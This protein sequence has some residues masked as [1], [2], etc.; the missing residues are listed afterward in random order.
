MSDISTEFC[1]AF[2]DSK[3]DERLNVIMGWFGFR[4][5][6]S[7]DDLHGD[8]LY[9]IQASD[10]SFLVCTPAQADMG[11]T[12]ALSS[13]VD[14]RPIKPFTRKEFL[15]LGK[16]RKIVLLTKKQD[17]SGE[18]ESVDAEQTSAAGGEQDSAE[19]SEA[20]SSDSSEPSVLDMGAFG[21]LLTAA[22]RS[23]LVAGADQ[24]AYV[25][26]REFR[27]GKYD[28]AF[29]AIDAM[30]SRF[31]TSSSQRAQQLV[32]EDADIAAGRLKMSPK[33]LQA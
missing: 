12:I 18:G 13:V 22:Q 33:D 5:V 27:M 6:Q 23:G 7:E 26:D 1:R 2:S 14:D 11:E 30:F 9:F 31:T 10:Q 4:E 19:S 21:Q 29:Q 15:K 28:L 16:R 24:I 32:R 25:R 3:G 17:S 20:E 8:S